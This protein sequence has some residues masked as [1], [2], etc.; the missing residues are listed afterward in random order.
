VGE[1]KKAPADEGDPGAWM[2]TFADLVTLL[3]TFFV[4]LL[5]MSSLDASAVNDSFGF[6][7]AQPGAVGDGQGNGE[8]KTRIV[9]PDPPIMASAP[10]ADKI[11]KDPE[12]G[13][14]LYM[15]SAIPS[16]KE[17]KR[18]KPLPPNEGS[19]SDTRTKAKGQRAE[20]LLPKGV[21]MGSKEDF[22]R[23]TKLLA[24]PRYADVLKITRENERA[25]IKFQGA[26]LF[27]E[28]RVRLRPE[29]LPLLEEVGDLIARLGFHARVLGVIAPDGTD[30]P[31]Q[32]EL[33]P[34]AWDLAIGRSCQVVRYL[35]DRSSLPEPWL[36]C[37]ALDPSMTPEDTRG[38][39]IELQAPRL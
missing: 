28:G 8:L 32:T 22:Q 11:S 27:H 36:S 20:D 18:P 4:L 2:A 19:L 37:S 29:S 1:R 13:N 12:R 35:A 3:I 16:A 26:L 9:V 31:V 33:Y 6:F 30:K 25:Q 14:H 5:S 21:G 24:D 38:V 10:A 15:P 17:S 34:T 7:D 39:V 23:I